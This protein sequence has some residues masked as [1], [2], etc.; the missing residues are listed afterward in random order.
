MPLV[1]C[2]PGSEPC[3]HGGGTAEK[4][5]MSFREVRTVL[6][7]SRSWAVGDRNHNRPLHRELRYPTLT[8]WEIQPQRSA[9]V[10]GGVRSCIHMV[11]T[12][13]GFWETQCWA[14]SQTG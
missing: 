12:W 4:G 3:C 14:L 5:L 8:S 6:A 10:G 13:T 1:P 2:V 7:S 9:W 11:R